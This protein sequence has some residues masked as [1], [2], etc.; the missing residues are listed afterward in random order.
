MKGYT[1]FKNQESWNILMKKLILVFMFLNLFSLAFAESTIIDEEQS[2][3]F[4]NEVDDITTIFES[5]LKYLMLFSFLISTM[6]TS[7][8]SVAPSVREK[9]QSAVLYTFFGMLLSWGLP[10]IHEWG[11]ELA[12]VISSSFFN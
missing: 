9:A 11:F 3:T 8:S 7:I 5:S 4:F 6:I 2:E 12:E 1:I 10:L